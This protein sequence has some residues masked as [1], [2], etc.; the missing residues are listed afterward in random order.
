MFPSRKRDCAYL[1]FFLTHIPIIYL[2]D[3]VP[4]QP[5]W[6]QSSLSPPIRAFYVNTYRDKFFEAAPVWFQ[7]FMWMELLYHVPLSLWAVWALMKDHP[8]VPVHLL[9]FGVQVVVTTIACLATVWSWE[10]RTVEEKTSLTSLYGPYI[11]LGAGMAIDM[12]LRLQSQ[13]SP[14]SKRE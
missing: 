7:S 9:G 10:D 1:F 2:I 5:A 3:T 4:L 8:F 12:A 14:K 13:L 11:A 6:L